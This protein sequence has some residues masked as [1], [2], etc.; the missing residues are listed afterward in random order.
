[1]SSTT[2]YFA[3]EATRCIY[4]L[5]S[6]TGQSLLSDRSWSLTRNCVFFSSS[7]LDHADTS[8]VLSPSPTCRIPSGALSRLLSVV[9]F[10]A[11]SVDHVSYEH[12]LVLVSPHVLPYFHGYAIPPYSGLPFRHFLPCNP[13]NY[14]GKSLLSHIPTLYCHF[15]FLMSP[16]VV[17]K[18][19]RSQVCS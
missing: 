15:D 6:T 1:M 8:P 11:P 9:A 18:R 19:V 16:H 10:L 12:H 4:F 2:H 13:I 7:P 3:T 14:G 17:F 5:P